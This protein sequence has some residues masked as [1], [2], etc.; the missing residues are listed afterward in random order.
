M[1]QNYVQ[2]FNIVLE[3]EGLLGK[4][5]SEKAGFYY[6][7]E[8]ASYIRYTAQS[9]PSLKISAWMEKSPATD[10]ASLL[11]QIAQRD[12]LALSTLYDRYAR[13]IYSVAFKSLQSVEESE[14]VVLDV[15]AQVW[16]IADRYDVR[17]G[18]VDTWL[19][20]L[21]RSR[22]LDRLRK[23]QRTRPS[24]TVSIEASEIQP[25][26][27]NVDLYEDVF[28]RERRDRV[29]AAMQTLPDEQRL[30]LELAYY[31]GL[32]QSEIATQTGLPLGTVKTRTRLGLSKLKSAL[33]T[34][35]DF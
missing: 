29:V 6:G 31:Q 23:L 10:D 22:I 4:A 14:E 19:F 26:A 2:L 32:S 16:R 15:F 17:K 35:E 3:L 18:K 30:I 9:Y 24:T 11:A 33:G 34:K 5:F 27:D 20:T 8:K 21:T 7:Y 13:I 1:T 12:Q 25:K 28:M